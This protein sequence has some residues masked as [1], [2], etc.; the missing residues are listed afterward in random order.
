MRSRSCGHHPPGAERQVPDLGVAHHARRAGPTA[1]PEASSS[2]QGYSASQR[3]KIGRARE[4][5]GVAVRRAG[6]GPSRRRSGERPA[7]SSSARHG[8]ARPGGLGRG[9]AVR[10]RKPA[11]EVREHVHRSDVGL[12]GGVVRREIL[13]DLAVARGLA[14]PC[15]RSGRSVVRRRKSVWSSGAPAARTRPSSAKSRLRASCCRS[16]PCQAE[17]SRASSAHE[18]VRGAESG[19]GGAVSRSLAR[20]SGIR[21]PAPR[22]RGGPTQASKNSKMP[23]SFHWCSPKVS[24]S[25]K[26][27]RTSPVG[28]RR[29]TASNFSAVSGHSSHERLEKRNGDVV[30]QPVV[31]QE[32]RQALRPSAAR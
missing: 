22:E 12:V 32:Q 17:R 25:M 1:S 29:S 13:V 6:R 16:L 11:L 27:D 10:A 4:R 5:D 28:A 18:S 30:G 2:V 20:A 8:L 21:A 14:W 31:A 9:A 3:S 24:K 7:P 19:R 15:S 23:V 26:S